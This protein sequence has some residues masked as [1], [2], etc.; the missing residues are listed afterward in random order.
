MISPESEYVPFLRPIKVLDEHSIPR[1][2]EDWLNEIQ[3]DMILCLNNY[4]YETI[5]DS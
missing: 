3:T 5:K 4:S 2:I 1:N